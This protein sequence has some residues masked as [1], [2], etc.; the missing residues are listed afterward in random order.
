MHAVESDYPSSEAGWNFT[1]NPSLGTNEIAV[2]ASLLA[3]IVDGSDDAI[4][5]KN[6]V[7]IITSWNNGAERIFG[8]TAAEA[9]GNPI[10][11]IADA[12]HVDEM[13][14]ILER[15][16]DGQRIDHYETVRQ[17]KGGQ[18]VN[19]S[20]T[21][22]PMYDSCGRVVE[23]SKI[24]RDITDRKRAEESLAKHTERIAR[25]NAD[26]QQYI[27]SHDLKEPLRTI[28]ACTEMFLSS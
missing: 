28:V 3:A 21:V 25:A 22:S 24:A 23:P 6:L 26:L 7:G 11:M 2:S 8:Y 18:R 19:I 13:P 1:K 9:I 20:L 17:A 5:S 16:R 15:I 14:T 10:V 12:E 4:I 27:T